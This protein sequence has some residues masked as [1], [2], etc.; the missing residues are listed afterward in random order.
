V[1]FNGGKDCTVLLELYAIAL[2]R[3]HAKR[4]G[5]DPVSASSHINGR[6]TQRPI[7][8]VYIFQPNPFPDVEQFISDTVQRYGSLSTCIASSIPLLFFRYNLELTRIDE[9]QIKQG[10][11]K[12]LSDHPNIK[13]ILVGTRRTDPHARMSFVLLLSS[14]CLFIRIAFSENLET[15]SQT[16]NGWPSFMRVNPIIDWN[17]VHVWRFL[18]DRHVPYCTIYNLG[19]TSL[20]SVFNTVPNPHLRRPDGSFAPAYELVEDRFERAGRSK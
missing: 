7:R 13:A 11:T 12:Y 20:G 16:D 8:S 2:E 19:Y 15:F 5:G 1:S 9:S 18:R 3:H 4:N 10:L 6:Y 14:F 17:Y